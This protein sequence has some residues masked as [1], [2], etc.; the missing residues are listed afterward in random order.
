MKR[1]GWV[2]SNSFVH[3]INSIGLRLR[4]FTL[5]GLVCFSPSQFNS[6]QSLHRTI[7]STPL[8][9][10][11]F[12]LLIPSNAVLQKGVLSVMINLPSPNQ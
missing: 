6:I 11:P 9:L 10:R 3:L 12:V 4:L 5:L 7:R 8:S 2:K 1:L